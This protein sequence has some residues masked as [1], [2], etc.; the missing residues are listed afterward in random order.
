ML[1]RFFFPLAVVLSARNS[2]DFLLGCWVLLEDWAVRRF[3]PDDWFGGFFWFQ[4]LRTRGLTLSC[5]LHQLTPHSK[6][7]DSA[8]RTSF[9]DAFLASAP[10]SIN[11]HGQPTPTAFSALQDESTALAAKALSLIS[12]F[13]TVS[14]KVTAATF[15]GVREPPEEVAKAFREVEEL[16]DDGMEVGTQR[17]EMLVRNLRIP[18]MDAQG[19]VREVSERLFPG[20]EEGMA[21]GVV[22]G[23]WGKELAR[24][25][26]G[27]RKMLGVARTVKV[28]R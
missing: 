3:C 27:V 18:R 20:F 10:F 19:R 17:V 8:F 9:R 21:D 6:Q 15:T 7:S 28:V 16:L 23:R 11:A 5:V 1:C 24:Q 25:E 14:A 26:K 2:C 12:L 4:S 22:V 13:N